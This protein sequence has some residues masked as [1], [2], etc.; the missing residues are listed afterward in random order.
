M[1]KYRAHILHGE[2]AQYLKEVFQ[3]IAE[4]YEFHIDTMEVLEDHVHVFV[5]VSP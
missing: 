2:M 5:E 1:P 3:R 4:E